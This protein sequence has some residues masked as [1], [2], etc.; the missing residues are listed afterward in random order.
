MTPDMLLHQKLSEAAQRIRALRVCR[1]T[2]R[3]LFWTALGCL[4]WLLASKAAWLPEPS[5]EA[6]V[7]ALALA[8]LIGAG[9]GF[10][11]HITP[12]DAARLTEKRTEMKERLSSAVEFAARTEDDPLVRRQIEDAS[13]HA[14]AINVRQVY[15]LRL[16]REMVGFLVLALALFG[17]LFLP[18]LPLF[19]SAEQKREREQV[20]RHGAAI[21]KIARDHERAASEKR[22]EETK[23]AAKEAR[24]LAEA[25]KRGQMSKKD[26][27]VQ[28]RK[29]TKQMQEQQKRLAAANTP[30]TK[31]LEQ[32]AE[33]VKRALEQQQKAAQEAAKA[34]QA[35][36]GKQSDPKSAQA[37]PRPQ[38][39]PTQAMRQAQEALQKFADA[40]ATQNFEAQNQALQEIASQM[41][42]GQMTP[43]EMQQLQKQMQALAQALKSTDLAK[44]SK[45]LAELAKQMQSSDLDPETLKR[46][47]TLLRQAGGACRGSG[48]G[49]LDAKQLAALLEALKSGRLQLAMGN[50]PG[51]SPGMGQ[52][53]SKQKGSGPGGGK[54]GSGAG[55]AP[56]PF[57]PEEK[58]L[59]I[60]KRAPNA[61][62]TG[63]RSSLK[64]RSPTL[65]F[66]SDPDRNARAATPY[67]QVYQQQKRVAESAVEKENIPAPVRR[68]VKDYFESIKP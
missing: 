50:R 24:K 22:L 41:Q 51:Q 2:A 7:G 20:K 54:G 32:A 29:L 58:N 6:L 25:M 56:A 67:Y 23:K 30:G 31:S 27:M 52:G 33:E 39:Q 68:L 53:K 5:A 11:R 4:L 64:D 42:T 19:W 66:K 10:A 28:M 61:K 34:T 8:A 55:T 60:A 48:Q 47:A 14:R 1:W 57:Q 37:Q 62:V 16:S 46:L 17:A 49:S 45:Q 40:L 18:T 44:A 43:Q 3:L 15:P 35:K 13:A 12:M 59:K 9:I 38:R 26:A 21:E 65:A 63:Q 36:Q